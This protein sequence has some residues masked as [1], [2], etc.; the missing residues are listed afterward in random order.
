MAHISLKHIILT[1]ICLFAGMN[2]SAYDALIN[3][4]YYNFNENEATV[5]Y[6]SEITG[7]QCY[8]GSVVIPSTVTYNGKTYTVTGIGEWA[9]SYCLDLT[10]I[11]IPNSVSSIGEGAFNNCSGLN[12]IKVNSGNTKYDSRGGCNAI[13]ETATN[14]LIA[15]CQNTTIPNSVTGIGEWAFSGCNGLTSV[16]IPNSV[17]GIGDGAFSACSGLTSIIIPNSVTV[18]NDYAFS[19]CS[20]LNSVTIPNSVTGIGKNAFS[21]CVGLTSVT[22]PNSVTSIGENAFAM[23]I[24][25]ASV[26]IPESVT[27][28]D[29][30]TFY[31][32]TDLTSITIPNT[33]TSIGYS[34]F[35]SCSGLTS[36]IIPEG[37]TNINDYAFYNCVGLTS[38]TIGNSV[39]SIGN[40]AFRECSSLKEIYC[41]AEETPE[42]AV[43][44]FYKV[45]VSEV[46]LVVPDDALEKYRAHS[47]W[48]KFWVESPTGILPMKNGRVESE[49]SADAVY[50]LSGQPVGNGKLKPG[51]YI[52]NGKKVMVK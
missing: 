39:T 36:I 43:Y 2:A 18:I 48:C 9:F 19:G 29:S 11:N 20:G 24:H 44:T 16:T 49:K 28:I 3:D 10:S 38:V 51:I 23:C 7:D 35:E 50:N 22:I 6:R 34:A 17:S 26:T 25:L 21:G 46:L 45:N 15:G 1:C 47:V 40:W 52:V 33:V 27:S 4:I 31:N 5:T 37:V 14:T 8:S 32:C 42:V 12:S 41:Y 30:Y 13:I